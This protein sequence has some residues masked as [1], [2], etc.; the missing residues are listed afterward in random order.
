MRKAGALSDAAADE[1][2]PIGRAVNLI[3]PDQQQNKSVP[4]PQVIQQAP[5]ILCFAGL[6]R[7]VLELVG[8]VPAVMEG[9]LFGGANGLTLPVLKDAKVSKALGCFSENRA[10]LRPFQYPAGTDIYAALAGR[11]AERVCFRG[12]PCQGSY[13]GRKDQ[14]SRFLYRARHAVQERVGR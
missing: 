13:H 6:R 7:E 12:G 11:F 8:A 9:N 2:C 3:D 10:S 1:C 14:L 4:S 5:R